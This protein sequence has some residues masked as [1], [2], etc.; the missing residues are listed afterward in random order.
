MIWED[1]KI[2][3]K[4]KLAESRRARLARILGVPTTLVSAAKPSLFPAVAALLT[5]A[6]QVTKRVRLLESMFPTP[7]ESLPTSPPLAPAIALPP[8]P[9]LSSANSEPGLTKAS[10]RP[11]KRKADPI[12]LSADDVFGPATTISPAL[13]AEAS[14]ILSAFRDAAVTDVDPSR[15]ET[16]SLP[17]PVSQQEM[18]MMAEL[19]AFTEWADR[20]RELVEAVERQRAIWEQDSKSISRRPPILLLQGAGPNVKEEERSK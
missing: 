1:W 9:A 5:H 7:T 20:Q 12:P 16:Y 4:T 13:I 18:T 15:P 11:R 19:E 10:R 14:A 2:W 3:G 6:M 8:S 17:L